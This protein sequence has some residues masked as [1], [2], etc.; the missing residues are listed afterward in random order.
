MPLA[1]KKTINSGF[2]LNKISLHLEQN[3]IFKHFIAEDLAN[4]FLWLIKYGIHRK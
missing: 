2:I 4:F 3:C 1:S